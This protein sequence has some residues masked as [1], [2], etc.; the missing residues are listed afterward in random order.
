[1]TADI[2]EWV[3]H[4]ELRRLEETGTEADSTETTE[5]PSE[6]PAETPAEKPQE[7]P[8]SEPAPPAEKP[9]SEA[10]TSEEDDGEDIPIE[11]QKE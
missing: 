5:Q 2:S 6:K 8:K 1:M 3:I 11:K 9:K 10:T 4:D 7:K